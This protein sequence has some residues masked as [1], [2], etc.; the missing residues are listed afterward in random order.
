MPGYLHIFRMDEAAG[1]A[2]GPDYQVNYSVPG[3][4][5]VKSVTGDDELAAFLLHD[6]EVSSEDADRALTALRATGRATIPDVD[7]PVSEASAMGLQ[8]APSDE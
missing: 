5:F 8:R 7:I 4:S 6:A 1:G 2:G 3:N